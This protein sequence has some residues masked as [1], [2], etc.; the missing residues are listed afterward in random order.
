MQK[1]KPKGTPPAKILQAEV[2]TPDQP[3]LPYISDLL[4]NLY[5]MGHG[6]LKHLPL[7]KKLRDE[8]N[9]IEPWNSFLLELIACLEEEKLAP[10]EKPLHQWLSAY[11]PKI[12]E[13]IE[14]INEK[15][16]A[17]S[18]DNRGELLERIMVFHQKKRIEKNIADLKPKLF[19]NKEAP[20]GFDQKVFQEIQELY[21][22]LSTLSLQR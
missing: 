12:K 10:T 22:K 1:S 20:N 11:S 9:L 3:L 7:I 19:G 17:F 2:Q 18:C 13:F 5:F 21:R 14:S 8:V 6:D 4:A 15:K 16:M